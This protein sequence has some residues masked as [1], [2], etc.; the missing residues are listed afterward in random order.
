MEQRG[1]GISKV[2]TIFI[3]GL[4]IVTLTLMAAMVVIVFSN[5]L[6]R[7]F[8][9][10]SIAWSE[11]ISRMMMIWVVFLGAVLANGRSEHLGLDILVNTF[12][13]RIKDITALLA[14][15]LVGYALILVF[16]GGYDITMQSWDWAS[17]AAAIPYGY[18]YMIVPIAS[19]VL[20]I[21][22]CI[23]AIKH[24]GAIIGKKQNDTME[25]NQ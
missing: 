19:I 1:T 15:A 23:K 14:D 17:P 21:Q 4:E 9:N 6:S 18:V 10:L 7:Y 25:V 5:V 12:P 8:F 13:K 11:E 16:I 20:L 3:K 2:A 22:T 24:F